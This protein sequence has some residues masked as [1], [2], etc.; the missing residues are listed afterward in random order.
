RCVG[1]ENWE[2]SS[3]DVH[4]GFGIIRFIKGPSP[5]GFGWINR[6]RAVFHHDVSSRSHNAGCGQFIKK[7]LCPGWE[8]KVVRPVIVANVSFHV[9]AFAIEVRPEPKL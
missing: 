8:E 7:A 5:A 2:H 1:G 6:E 3:S 9:I 4:E